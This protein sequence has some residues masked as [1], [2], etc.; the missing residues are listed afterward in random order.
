ML[1]R[2]IEIA[3]GE[4]PEPGTGQKVIDGYMNTKPQVKE[5]LDWCKTLPEGQ[6]YYLSPSG[7]KR[8][9]KVPPLDAQM[10]DDLRESIV[11][12]LRR[13]ACNIGLQSLVADSLARAIPALNACFMRLHMKSR[14]VIPLYDAIYILA[15]YEEVDLASS[16]LKFFM[17]DNNYWDLKGGRLRYNIEVEVT[18][19]WSTAPS[20]EEKH[21]LQIGLKNACQK[22]QIR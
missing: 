6:G 9:F 18:K 8:H 15:P 14:A 20:E 13:E 22:Y 5:Y 4:K 16:M 12:K 17:S 7:F 19:R 2:K 21:E 1:E 3:A 10:S 11:S